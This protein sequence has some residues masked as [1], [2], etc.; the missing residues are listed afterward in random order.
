MWLKKVIKD[1]FLD[2][3]KDETRIFIYKWD[4]RRKKEKIFAIDYDTIEKNP[5]ILII[6]LPYP[7]FERK[8]NHL[9]VVVS[10]LEVFKTRIMTLSKT[11]KFEISEI[12]ILPDVGHVIVKDFSITD[13]IS[14]KNKGVV[15]RLYCQKVVLLSRLLQ[16]NLEY[17]CVQSFARYQNVIQCFSNV[18]RYEFFKKRGIILSSLRGGLFRLKKSLDG[19]DFSLSYIIDKEEKKIIPSCYFIFDNALSLE[20][21]YDERN[22]NIIG[23]ECCNYSS[24][25]SSNNNNAMMKKK[26]KIDDKDDE[27]L[28]LLNIL[29]ILENYSGLIITMNE[30]D[31]RNLQ[32]K[33]IFYNIN[34]L[35]PHWKLNIK[36]GKKGIKTSEIPSILYYTDECPSLETNSFNITNVV[37]SLLENFFQSIVFAPI[38]DP[39][40]LTK[41]EGTKNNLKKNDNIP[42]GLVL[43]PT[44][45]RHSNVTCLDFNSLYPNIMSSFGIIKGRVCRVSKNQLLMNDENEKI[46]YKY[47]HVLKLADDDF[48]YLSLKDGANPISAFCLYLIEKRI[49]NPKI[50]A[51]K[52]MINSLYGLFANRKFSLFSSTVATTIT[53]YGR[54][55]LTRAIQF[56]K[57]KFNLDCLYGDTDSIFIHYHRDDNNP[58]RL[59]SAYNKKYPQIHLKVESVFKRIILIRKKLYF[60]KIIE[61]DKEKKEDEDRKV[62]TY[63]FSGFQKQFLSTFRKFL[64][65]L[66]SA[67]THEELDLKKRTLTNYFFDL[68]NAVEKNNKNFY[69]KAYI[70]PLL[71]VLK[72]ESVKNFQS[73]GYR[74]VRFDDGSKTIMRLNHIS[75]SSI[76]KDVIW[77]K[78]NKIK[79]KNNIIFSRFEKRKIDGKENNQDTSFH[80]FLLT[81]DVEKKKKRFFQNLEE[82]ENL[83]LFPLLGEA[84]LSSLLLYVYID[85]CDYHSLWIYDFL[86]FV[87]NKSREET[88]TKEKGNI[89]F[90]LPYDVLAIDNQ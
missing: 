12:Y 52:L 57:T 33:I 5:T 87:Y 13:M 23:Y 55:F 66:V 86:C 78:R 84:E 30:T 18:V 69:W 45:G 76:K 49:Q 88:F 85:S 38:N 72:M 11:Y 36:L 71:F 24:S 90:V 63:K 83:V 44:S 53:K 8:Y 16:K 9:T 54:F 10:N 15:V 20:L 62:Y 59:A 34:H 31:A 61:E 29:E 1:I 35:Y 50:S 4:T 64:S 48:Y 75:F 74:I 46:I 51:F 79:E 28:W 41:F 37:V 32:Q 65:G 22:E 67:E 47:F 56:F 39:F 21:R 2:L 77:K 89:A 27:K 81:L 6:S 19:K 25:S 3:E 70:E 7:Q 14:G 42:G 68:E 26:E 43:A 17:Y 73:L 40:P 80:H 60:G 82:L 58:Q